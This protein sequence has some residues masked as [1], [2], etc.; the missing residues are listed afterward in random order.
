MKPPA[1]R[2]VHFN[3]YPG[4]AHFD[5]MATKKAF[6]LPAERSKKNIKLCHFAP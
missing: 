1:G 2:A 6:S 5:E 3:H 4:L